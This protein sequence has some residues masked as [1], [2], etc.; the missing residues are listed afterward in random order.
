MQHTYALSSGVSIWKAIAEWYQ[1]SLICEI[2][3]YLEETYFSV[4]FGSYKNFSVSAS[5]AT[6]VRNT[7][8]GIAIGIIIASAMMVHT[9]KGI[10]GF[11]RTLLRYDC[12]SPET[13]K[14]LLELGYFKN[15][16]IRRELKRGVSL[17][18]LVHCKER[19]AA[20]ESG[21]FINETQ[22]EV[23]KSEENFSIDFATMH[24]Y[25]PEELRYRA[26]IRFDKKGSTW[27]FFFVVL[28]STIVATALLCT[29]LPE[30][31]GLIDNIY[32]LISP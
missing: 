14:T 21:S 28:I 16:S 19:E 32:T 18:K 4:S 1:D 23:T 24:F 2:F 31:F 9:K 7:I 27:L 26:E 12:T 15:A 17:C 20:Q 25:I 13:A 8:I 6:T 11:V 29:L 22:Q 3:T 30:F 10:G 5:T